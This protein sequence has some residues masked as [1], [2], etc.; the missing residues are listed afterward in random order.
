MHS[1]EIGERTSIQG[2]NG[3]LEG[4]NGTHT[5]TSIS[6]FSVVFLFVQ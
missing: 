6:N 5:H 3:S 1:E 4:K 2:G